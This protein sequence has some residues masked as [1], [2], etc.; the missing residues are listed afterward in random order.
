MMG[1][2]WGDQFYNAKKKTWT[3][4]EVDDSKRGFCQFVLDPILNMHKKI[5]AGD[6][7]RIT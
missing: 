6:A 7:V 3:K 1:R 5:L 2:L 4:V